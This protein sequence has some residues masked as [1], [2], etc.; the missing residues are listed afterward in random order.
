MML[1][2]K[3]LYICFCANLTTGV[4][5]GLYYYISNNIAVSGAP[6]L[7]TIIFC[8]IFPVCMLDVLSLE[9]EDFTLC[10]L[11]GFIRG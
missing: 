2:L 9:E 1:H 8:L 6:T 10:L 7:E 11:E 3:T 4:K 5:F